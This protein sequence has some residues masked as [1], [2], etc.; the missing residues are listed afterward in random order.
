MDYVK[1]KQ[2]LYI[3][4]VSVLLDSIKMNLGNVRLVI[5]YVGHVM[6]Q[7]HVLLV[8]IR[9]GWDLILNHFNA[10]VTKILKPQA[11]FLII[12]DK[13]FIM[14]IHM[15]LSVQRER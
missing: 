1:M 6:G 12:V 8:L 3:L 14:G 15:F 10:N 13:N 2:N 7:V 4:N 5:L 11:I 9:K